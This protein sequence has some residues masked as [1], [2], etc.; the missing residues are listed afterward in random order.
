MLERFLAWWKTP[1]LRD[2]VLEV[3]RS[4]S[5]DLTAIDIARDIDDNW[6]P[7]GRVYPVLM[8]LEREGVVESR[9]LTDV[10]PRRRVYWLK[11]K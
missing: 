11:D 7:L 2:R 3:L 8:R 5:F 1:P 9:W 4:Y 10:R 6:P